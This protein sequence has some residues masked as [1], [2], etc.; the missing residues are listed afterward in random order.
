MRG[1]EQRAQARIRFAGG[2]RSEPA[3][4]TGPFDAGR[5]ACIGLFEGEGREQFGFA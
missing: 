2:A 1:I 4:G 5:H 3:Q